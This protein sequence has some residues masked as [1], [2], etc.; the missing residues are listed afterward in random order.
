M[1]KFWAVVPAAGIGKRMRADKPK[2]YLL[3]DGK[4]VLER[5]LSRLSTH[6]K[7]NAVIVAT[8]AQDSYWQML[9][10]EDSISVYRV[11]GGEERCHS[12]LNCLAFLLEIADADDWVLVHDAA[13]PCVRTIDIDKL[14]HSIVDHPVGSILGIPVSDTLKHCDSSQVIESTPSRQNLWRALTPQLFQLGT[15]HDALQQALN[16][17]LMVTDDASA[18]ELAGLKPSI[19]AGHSDNIKITQPSDLTLA[20]AYLMLQKDELI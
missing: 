20:S 11:E 10:L 5:T 3:L 2:Q 13:R 18:I 19:I 17:N 9:K 6:P 12:V 15:L 1:T 7:I 8:S 14:I 4:T 16:N